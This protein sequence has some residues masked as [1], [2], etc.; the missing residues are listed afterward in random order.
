MEKISILAPSLPPHLFPRDGNESFGCVCS[1]DSLKW[2]FWQAGS[3]SKGKS[4]YSSGLYE[5]VRTCTRLSISFI[6]LLLLCKFLK[7]ESSS[8]GGSKELTQVIKWFNQHSQSGASEQTLVIQEAL[9]DWQESQNQWEKNQRSH[10]IK[11][12]EAS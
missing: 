4:L 8:L 11:K 9:K 2:L 5:V 7:Q 1:P 12:R 6:S 10:R 3:N